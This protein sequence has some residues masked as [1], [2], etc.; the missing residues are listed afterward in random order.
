MLYNLFLL[1]SLITFLPGDHDFHKSKNNLYY[2]TDKQVL[3]YSNHIIQFK[4]DNKQK[5]FH[6][7]TNKGHRK[8]LSL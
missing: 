5:A 3:Q 8:S 4:I 2:E 1:G 6:I 7:L